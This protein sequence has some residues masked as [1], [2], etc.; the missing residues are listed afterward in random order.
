MIKLHEKLLSK[1]EWYR[2]W[3]ELK[4][5]PR[6]H[7]ALLFLMIIVVG[8]FIYRANQEILVPDPVQEIA[9]VGNIHVNKSK[10]SESSKKVKPP[11]P[12][13]EIPNL[14]RSE[15]AISALGEKL[16]EIASWYG[17]TSEQLKNMFK[18]DKNLWADKKG[19]LFYV[20]EGLALTDNTVTTSDPTASLPVS[21]MYSLSQT[22][23]LH[24][25]P[26]SS[27]IIYLDFNGASI[28]N[29]AWNANYNSGQTITA[30][31]FD[32]DGNPSSFNDTELQ[33]IQN[34]WL[35]VA[36]DYAPFDVDITTEEPA[37]GYL[38]RRYTNTVVI[39]PTNFY[40]NAGGVSYVGSFDDTGSYYKY[41]WAFSNM[42]QNSEKYIA[43]CISHESGHSVGLHHEGTTSG[44][45]YYQGQGNWAPIMGNSYYK[46]VTQWAK[47]E[48]AGANNTEDQLQVMQNYG[49]IYYSDDHGDNQTTAESLIANGTSITGKGIIGQRTDVDVFKFVSGSGQINITVTPAIVTNSGNI[50]IKAELRDGL[51][52][53]I[54]SSDPTGISATINAIV[55]GGT[56]YLFIDGVGEADPATTGYSDYASLGQYF[57]NGTVVYDGTKQSPLAYASA[58]PISGNPPLTVQFSSNNSID[59]DGY[60]SSYTWSFG[61]G[62]NSTEPNP[63][64]TYASFGNYTATLTVKDN[65]NLSDSKSINISVQN[66]TPTAIMTA[67]PLSGN[68]PL[69]VNFNGSN[70]YDPDGNIYSYEWNFGDGYSGTGTTTN[71]SYS[72]GGNYTAQL[73][74]TDNNDAQ[75]SIT[76][77]ISVIDPNLISAPTNLISTLN[78][79]TVTLN[80]KDNSN[81]E[82]GFYIER[83]IKSKNKSVSVV[84]TKVGEVGPNVKTYTENIDIGSYYYRVRAFNSFNTS[85]YSNLIQVTRR[86]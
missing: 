31:P 56:Y 20:D 49:L 9:A 12:S 72:A 26:G 46:S 36:E 8:N 85:D 76:S 77:T 52:S 28:S 55:P 64:K 67:S 30:A 7:W 29:T 71:H 14:V 50:N 37:S 65:D 24:S 44:T 5:Y 18:K 45:T 10:T 34:I 59:P 33:R 62:T 1:F 3:H 86:K 74:V 19:R 54:T 23:F 40:P 47:G 66:K 81:N 38:E 57:I 11:F 6:L 63:Q 75:S 73:T 82:S 80:W 42:L 60:I 16:P 39:T 17:K 27:K 4:I 22:F 83:A 32:L 35:R 79:S 48:Y 13:V 15:A 70:S 68:A 51:G 61:D 41:S 25:N 53:L 58:S 78:K 84:Y 69:T 21:Q 43:E 2:T